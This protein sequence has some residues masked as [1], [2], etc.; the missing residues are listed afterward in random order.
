MPQP[1]P[2]QASP[3]S[4]PCTLLMSYVL[5][6]KVGYSSSFNES[7]SC[8]FYCLNIWKILITVK[9]QWMF[10][11]SWRWS[12]RQSPNLQEHCTCYF[13]HC[14]LRGNH[15]LY[16]VSVLYFIFLIFLCCLSRFWI[17][18]ACWKVCL[19]DIIC[20]GRRKIAAWL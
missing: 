18:F 16:W 3:Q 14:S 12:C 2:S 4:P 19:G 7:N 11:N 9:K 10:L 20:W 6:F 5:D 17:D 1:V 13:K 8:S 15:L